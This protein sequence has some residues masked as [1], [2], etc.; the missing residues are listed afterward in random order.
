MHLTLLQY[1]G[2]LPH[3]VDFPSIHK[4]LSEFIHAATAGRVRTLLLV[5]SDMLKCNIA[6]SFPRRGLAFAVML[7]PGYPLA[8][9][10]VA[11]PSVEQQR[12]QWGFYLEDSGTDASS[13][14]IHQLFTSGRDFAHLVPAPAHALVLQCWSKTH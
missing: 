4:H 9:F 7:R 14:A 2:S 3:F 6:A 8:M 12:R 13:T 10:G 5:G 1:E 11:M